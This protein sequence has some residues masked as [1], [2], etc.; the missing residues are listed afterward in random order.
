[1]AISKAIIKQYLSSGK[2]LTLL[3]TYGKR[4]ILNNWTKKLPS[5]ETVLRHEGNLGWVIGDGYLVVDVDIKNGGRDSFDR[6]CK[7]VGVIDP[8]VMT[9]SGGWHCYLAVD[10]WEGLT[11]RKNLPEYPGID[12]LTKGMQCVI[13][14]SQVANGT[15]TY[16]DDLF[17]EPVVVEAPASLLGLVSFKR[18]LAAATPKADDEDWA[19]G[20]TWAEEKVQDLLDKLDPSMEYDSWMKVGMALH[21]WDK[22]LGIRLWEEWSKRGINYEEGA[23]YIKWQSFS[24]RV[25]GKAVTL[26]SISHMAMRV[27]YRERQ[28]TVLNFLERIRVSSEEQLEFEVSKAI[29][30]EEVDKFGLERLVKAY[31]TRMAEL[32]GVKMGIGSIRNL[33]TNKRPRADIEVLG[34]IGQDKPDWVR[35][36]MYVNSHGGFVDL[37]SFNVLRPEAFNLAHG[38]DVPYSDG[39]TKSSAIKYV[40]DN[41]MIPVVESMTYLP[42]CDSGIVNIDGQDV[43]NCFRR[44][45]VPVEDDEISDEAWE[46]IELVKKHIR[47]IFGTEEKSDIFL[48][49]LAWQIQKPGEKILWTP[50]IRSIEGVGKSFF[51]EMLRRCL[52]DHNVGTVN[53]S[54]VTSNFNGWAS[55]VCVNVLEEMRVK[56]HNRYEV[57]NSL[58]PLITDR[59]IQI[60]EKN[61]KP[62]TTY[63]TCNYLCFTNYVDAIPL[64]ED[65][66][67]WWVV[68]VPFNTLAEV[69]RVVG[70]PLDKYY[71]RLFRGVAE[72]AGALRKWLLD[73]EI[74]GWFLDMKRA[75]M[76]EDK[77]R[78]IFS[79][80]LDVEGFVELREFID[81]GGKYYNNLI[82]SSADLFNAFAF[83]HPDIQ[84]SNREK[85]AM[86]KK[87]G[88]QPLGDKMRIGDRVLRI[89]A[90]QVFTVKEVKRMFEE[91]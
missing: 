24:A 75:P 82:V 32:T 20:G 83:E 28:K 46:Y 53:P 77:R 39:G 70:E 16:A 62:Y 71:P 61:V 17:G 59:I 37:K 6:L 87:L 30:K 19:S 86:L 3:E 81:V 4:P 13:P 8:T 91:F 55:G 21:H 18:G 43:L 26:G 44:E 31:Q 72:H 73:Y 14:G 45:L 78:M 74:P 15:Y 67:R 79:E 22:D 57:V 2:P 58:K 1:M 25:E 49:W 9:P 80:E 38:G 89:W 47:L 23:T 50:I 84:L 54:Q 64:T 42:M 48:A 63:N 56:G 33:L 52:G 35:N 29:S 69:E 85:N 41:K 40:A 12:F 10:G 11:W 90:K 66:R 5:E 36:Y 65:D 51:G 76:T 7:K 88:Y 68:F 60:N 34:R 27:E